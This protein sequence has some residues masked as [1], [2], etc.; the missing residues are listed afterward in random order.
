MAKH[1]HRITSEGGPNKNQERSEGP[2]DQ[3]NT[4][5]YFR[6][7]NAV[8]KEKIDRLMHLQ[9]SKKLFPETGILQNKIRPKL[10]LAKIDLKY[11]TENDAKD[12]IVRLEDDYEKMKDRLLCQ[13]LIVEKTKDEISAKRKEIDDVKEKMEGM[14][15]KQRK[16][17]YDVTG[18]I[19]VLKEELKKAG[20]DDKTQIYQIID[21]IAEDLNMKNLKGQIR[22]N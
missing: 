15:Q 10:D 11:V 17:S 20:V 14:L 7:A 21:D 5:Q 2:K 18:Q 13:E 6:L 12:L 16:S 22:K 19:E 3:S 8:I 9:D 4:S 1:A